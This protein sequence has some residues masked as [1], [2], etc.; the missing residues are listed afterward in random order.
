MPAVS[1]DNLAIVMGVAFAVP[2][3]L[4]LAPKV[5]VPAVVVEIVAGILI[6]PDVLGWAHADETVAIFAVIGLAFLLFLAGLE[7]DLDQLRGRL[8]W[9]AGLGFL[10][11]GALAVATGLV[12]D[13]TNQV[14]QPFLVAIILT[15]TSLGLVIPVLKEGGH[16]HTRL[17]QLVAAG[18]SIGDFGAIILLSLFFSRDTNDTTTRFVLLGAF[19]VAVTVIVLALRIRSHTMRIS[20][21][22]TRLGD[23]TAQ[24]RIRSSWSSSRA[25]A[26]DF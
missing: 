24:V 12:L 22:L 26:M 4:G 1:F 25:S 15:A 6:G 11:S 7:L 19:V 16:L 20:H 3:L 14:G 21:V 18:A 23:T 2:V 17:G 8:L 13:A 10:L 9:V 5:R